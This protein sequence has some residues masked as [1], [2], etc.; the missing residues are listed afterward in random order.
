MDNRN[1]WITYL[2]VILVG[3]IFGYILGAQRKNV[4]LWACAGV[5]IGF[6]VDLIIWY[7]QHREKYR[8]LLEDPKKHE[9]NNIDQ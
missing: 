2:A 8:N 7:T 5:A 6:F 3:G 4:E 1:K 9:N